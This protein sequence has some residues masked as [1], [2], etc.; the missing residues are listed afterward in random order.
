MRILGIAT[1]GGQ[2]VRSRWLH[3]SFGRGVLAGV[4]WGLDAV[5]DRGYPR[6][7]VELVNAV[8]TDLDAFTPEEQHVLERHGYLVADHHVHA[9]AADLIAIETPLAPPHP[10]V[11]DARVAATALADSSVRRL[12][13]RT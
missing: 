1:S 2:S 7:V 4:T 3:A 5:V 8:R 6:E 12:L 9:H 13:G 11:A 10:D